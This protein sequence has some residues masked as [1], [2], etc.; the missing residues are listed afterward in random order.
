MPTQKLKLVLTQWKSQV[1]LTIPVNNVKALKVR[2][3]QYKTAS[4]NNLDLQIGSKEMG[5]SGNY[6]RADGSTDDYFFAMPLDPQ[7]DV[8]NVFSNFT[9]E[10][11]IVY[12][13][14]VRSLDRFTFECLVNDA[15]AADI[16]PSN[17][18]VFEL[19]FLID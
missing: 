9:E 10:Y 18:L 4:A 16:T 15:P 5:I 13:Q 12:K 14:T 6:N 2:W 19:L 17:P 1:H 7:A 3:L 8:V 11:D